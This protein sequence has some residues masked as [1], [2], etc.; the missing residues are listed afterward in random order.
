MQLGL[1]KKV[2]TLLN[3]AFNYQNGIDYKSE[4]GLQMAFS[5]RNYFS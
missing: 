2:K 3:N 5:V 1:L 4:T